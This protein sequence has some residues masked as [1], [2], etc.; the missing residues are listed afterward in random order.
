MLGNYK[1]VMNVKELANALG[2]GRNKAYELI[3][4]NIIGSKRV[5]RR[6]LIPKI[7]VLDYLRSAR[8]AIAQE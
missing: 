1:D 7:C 3:N 2:I 8:Y 5:G 6:I 4:E